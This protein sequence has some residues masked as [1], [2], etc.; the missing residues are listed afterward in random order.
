[1]I[2]L[3]SGT[4]GSGKSL[5]ACRE[6]RIFLKS[7][8]PV[9]G[10]FSINSDCLIKKS[11]F[12]YTY[13][14]IYKLDP[15][16]LVEFSKTHKK[17]SGNPE[18]SFLLVIDEAQ[19]LFNS[20]SWNAPNRSEWITFFAEHRH[21]GFDII[22]ISQNDRMLDR[23]IRSLIEFNFIHRKYS[24]FGIAGRIFSFFTGQFVVVKVWYPLKEKVSAYFF[25]GS[26]KLYNFYDSYQL[27][28]VVEEGAEGSPDDT[29]PTAEEKKVVNFPT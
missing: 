2:S 12:E 14:D 6:I 10:T 5:N 20:R 27:F 17:K 3:F 15:K 13:I 24:Q 25:R 4:P 18:G 7:C 28:G 16:K 22:L 19:R 21:L 29:T 26:K 1:M 11:K 23:Q 9:I 8:G